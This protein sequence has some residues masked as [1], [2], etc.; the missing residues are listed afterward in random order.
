[1]LMM[2]LR[3]FS[4]NRL[5]HSNFRDHLSLVP[6]ARVAP[7]SEFLFSFVKM[8]FLKREHFLVLIV[9]CSFLSAIVSAEEPEPEPEPPTSDKPTFVSYLKQGTFWKLNL[10]KRQQLKAWT[11]ASNVTL[12]ASWLNQCAHLSINCNKKLTYPSRHLPVCLG[13][14]HWPPFIHLRGNWFVHRKRRSITQN[15][16]HLIVWLDKCAGKAN[17]SLILITNSTSLHWNWSTVLVQ[18]YNASTSVLL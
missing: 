14:L 1:M 8:I 10:P 15:A 9:T 17:Q 4:W 3:A 16:P 7:T 11:I 13:V 6:A 5:M 18:L 2:P 12:P